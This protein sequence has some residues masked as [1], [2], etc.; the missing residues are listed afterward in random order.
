MPVYLARSGWR[1]ASRRRSAFSPLRVSVSPCLRVS[2]LSGSS[3]PTCGAG[4]DLDRDGAAEEAPG[5]ALKAVAEAGGDP[6]GGEGRWCDDVERTGLAGAEVS[7]G[8]PV[9]V[10]GGCLQ[11]G[12]E[13]GPER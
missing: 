6:F 9:A 11:L 12:D 2:V 1:V 10:G 5:A 4:L 7:A 3:V 8:E 13:R